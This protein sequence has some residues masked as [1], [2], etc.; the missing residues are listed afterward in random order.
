M[1]VLTR[2]KE[3]S[4]MI[5]DDIEI[6]IISIGRRQVRLGIKAPK[7]VPV[8]RKEV[9]EKIQKMIAGAHKKQA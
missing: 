9:Y 4:I 3:E 5:G 2:G 1:L 7:H 8:H 6:C